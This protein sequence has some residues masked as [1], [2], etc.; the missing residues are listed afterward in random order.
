MRKTITEIEK[1]I[2]IDNLDYLYDNSKM[3]SEIVDILSNIYE[4]KN[5]IIENMLLYLVNTKDKKH[6]NFINLF[7]KNNESMNS[8]DNSEELYRV[9]NTMNITEDIDKEKKDDLDEKDDRDE[10]DGEDNDDEKEMYSASSYSHNSCDN[11]E[12]M[13]QK[14]IREGGPFTKNQALF[15]EYCK[16]NIKK[17]KSKTLKKK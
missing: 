7:R 3:L 17:K 16:S 13:L 12:M 10:D 5:K 9:L 11:S 8:I 2:N 6:E 1:P 14:L 4:K 15:L